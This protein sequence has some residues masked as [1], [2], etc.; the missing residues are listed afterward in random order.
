MLGLTW[1]Q[2][3]LGDSYVFSAIPDGT[4]EEAHEEYRPITEYLSKATSSQFIFHHPKNLLSYMREMRAGKY[5]LVFDDPHFVSWRVT[6][7]DHAPLVRL[8]GTLNF[9]IVARSNDEIV[10]N[11]SDLAGH[12]V[13][14]HAPPDLATL[15]MQTQFTNPV[16]QPQIF[17]VNGFGNIFE[18]LLKGSCR[19]AVIPSGL[20]AAFNNGSNKGKAR[21]LY[22]SEPIPR[23]AISAGPRIPENIQ[24][25]IRAALLSPRGVAVTARL[26]GR[27]ANAEQMVATGKSEFRGLE[28]LVNNL[29]GFGW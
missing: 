29:V 7:L 6:N 18:Q 15:S 26:R 19:G 11:L 28:T 13:C 3:C 25:L 17:E 10:F 5:D 9:V 4:R 2:L 27:F 16:R 12:K 20:Y 14:A 22:L 8:P 1:G 24:N 21:I 23:H